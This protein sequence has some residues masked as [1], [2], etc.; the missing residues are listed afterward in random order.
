METRRTVGTTHIPPGKTPAN[1]SLTQAEQTMGL[2]THSPQGPLGSSSLLVSPKTSPP[3]ALQRGDTPAGRD[4]GKHQPLLLS[5]TLRPRPGQEQRFPNLGTAGAGAPQHPQQLP[6]GGS[7]SPAKCPWWRLPSNSHFQRISQT[8]GGVS[9]LPFIGN[10][11]PALP[12]LPAPTPICQH[13]ERPRLSL[14]SMA[15]PMGA[16]MSP[17][18][19]MCPQPLC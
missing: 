5:L 6:Q 18:A 4:G 12:V 2:P 17:Q 9:I 7:P 15:T 16:L 10:S 13:T 11:A 8:L 19:A 1:S 14:P 3:M